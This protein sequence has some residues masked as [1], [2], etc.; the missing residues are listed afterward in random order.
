[1]PETMTQ[2]ESLI[3]Q[4]RMIR[5]ALENIASILKADRQQTMRRAELKRR[6]PGIP[7]AMLCHDLRAIHAPSAVAGDKLPGVIGYESYLKLVDFFKGE[8]S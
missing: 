1:M 2:T 7:E 8:K 5:A 6:F 4:Q 3:F